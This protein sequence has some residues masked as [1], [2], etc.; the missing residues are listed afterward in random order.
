MPDKNEETHIHSYLFRNLAEMPYIMLLRQKLGGMIWH[1]IFMS[2]LSGISN[3][4]IV[5]IINAA[6]LSHR[7]G[8]EDLIRYALMFL[9]AVVTYAFCNNNLL[10]LS[11]EMGERI[12]KDFRVR[13]AERI[14]ESELLVFD[15]LET[16]QVFITLSDNTTVIS[17]ASQPIFR[18]C[19]S[20]IMLLF[21]FAYLYI[22]SP[23]AFYINLFM[24]ITTVVVYMKATGE[25]ENLFSKAYSHEKKFFH[26]IMQLLDGIKE[27]KMNHLRGKDLFE[28]FIEPQAEEARE[29]K[30]GANRLYVRSYLLTKVFVFFVTAS[31]VFLLPML[32]SI[33]NEEMISLITVVLF[34][35]SPIGDIVEAMPEMAR[36][37]VAVKKLGELE[38]NLNTRESMETASPVKSI[39]HVKLVKAEFCYRDSNK[40]S[41]FCVGPIDMEF[42][43]GEIAFIVGGNG[44][45]KSTLL[46]MIAGLYPLERGA[47]I[48]DDEPVLNENR[49]MVRENFS[50]IFSGFHLFDHLYGMRDVNPLEVNAL[51][52]RMNLD[53][54]TTFRKGAFSRIDLSTGQRKRLALIVSLLEDR[55]IYIFDEVAADQDPQFREYFYTTI[56]NELRKLN[57]VVLVASHD[58][59]F[60]DKADKVYRLDYGRIVDTREPQGSGS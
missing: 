59:E 25:V 33:S 29:D 60:F 30:V 16:S 6:A 47:L 39:K 51:L 56:L 31:F 43:A 53:L 4:T 15:R 7:K 1:I 24:T 19:G 34:M 17:R 28:N 9:V 14:R 48:L 32:Q 55:P 37:N 36:A 50:A 2:F 35:I 38:Q 21:C 46:K 23:I 41:V 3:G 58:Q 49:Q 10:T 52:R 57:K 40:D 5:A 27:I 13:L 54:K 12:V 26:Y 42:R 45:G 8:E 22:I 11:V 20:S 18:A 44:S